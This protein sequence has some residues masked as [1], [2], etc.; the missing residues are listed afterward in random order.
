LAIAATQLF[1]PHF[2]RE[3][4]R[5]IL[6]KTRF[7]GRLDIRQLHNSTVV[8]DGAHNPQKMQA[9]VDTLRVLYSDKKIIRYT[10]FKQGKD[11]QQM[12]DI[13]QTVSQDFVL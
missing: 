12:L 6:E 7:I 5:S 9:L 11:R 3:K 1:C 4:T 8:L 13:M 10:A 2:D